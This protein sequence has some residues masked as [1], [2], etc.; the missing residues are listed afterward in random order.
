M[1]NNF[2]ISKEK[3]QQI[4]NLVLSKYGE[5]NYKLW[6][7][8]SL[9]INDKEISDITGIVTFVI[10][11]GNK[12]KN[13]ALKFIKEFMTGKNSKDDYKSYVIKPYNEELKED[14]WMP[15]HQQ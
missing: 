6:N 7:E 10:P 5:E 1:E 9:L 3:R 11:V 13:K 4:H 8:G 12:T 2:R 14:Y 15:V